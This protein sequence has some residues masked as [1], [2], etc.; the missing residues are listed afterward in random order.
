MAVPGGKTCYLAELKAGK[1]I[2][3]VDQNGIQ[4]TAVVGRVKIETRPLIIVDAKV[5]FFLPTLS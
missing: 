2:L 4:R 3:V 5:C 1:E